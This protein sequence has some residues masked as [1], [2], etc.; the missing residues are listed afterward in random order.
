MKTQ[1]KFHDGKMTV[2]FTGELDHHAARSAMTQIEDRIEA[3][4]PR[5]CAI[6]MSGVSFMDSSGIAVILKTY[7]RMNETGGRTWVENVPKQPMH[8]IDASGIDRLVRVTALGE[9]R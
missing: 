9:A 7:R 1:T 6:D 3:W 2:C 5:D 4:M 8:V